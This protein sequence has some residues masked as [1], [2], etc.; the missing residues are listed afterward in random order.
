MHWHRQAMLFLSHWKIRGAILQRTGKRAPCNDLFSQPKEMIFFFFFVT[1]VTT[2]FFFPDKEQMYLWQC[3]PPTP[4]S[5]HPS[6]LMLSTS[7]G[8][9]LR[10]FAVEFT[11]CI[12]FQIPHLGLP[13]LL[14]WHCLWTWGLALEACKYFCIFFSVHFNYHHK[15]GF[16][17][18]ASHFI[19]MD[20]IVLMRFKSDHYRI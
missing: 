1:S 14:L 18:Y 8:L 2:L 3:S 20:N 6:T 11:Y 7:A 16:V 5:T 13:H 17:V 12:S 10:R 9:S 19:P 15:V 4:G